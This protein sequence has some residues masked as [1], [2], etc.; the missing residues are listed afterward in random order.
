MPLG[1]VAQNSLIV[2][3]ERTLWKLI[4]EI[5]RKSR[6]VAYTCFFLPGSHET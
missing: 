4:L 5:V 3:Q 2:E 6:A 1:G